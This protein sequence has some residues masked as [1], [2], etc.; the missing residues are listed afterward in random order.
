MEPSIL[1]SAFYLAESIGHDWTEN[2]RDKNRSDLDFYLSTHI[3]WRL[4]R[5]V[6]AGSVISG[7]KQLDDMT[8]IVDVY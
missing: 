5:K 2:S 6:S 4:K 8:I 3:C 7:L 1:G